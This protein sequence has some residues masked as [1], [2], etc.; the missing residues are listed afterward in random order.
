MAMTYDSTNKERL[1]KLQPHV[2]KA[3]LAALADAEK[4]GID[5]LITQ[6]LRTYAE[7]NAL[8]AKGRTAP[9]SI[10]TNARGGYSYHNF[11]L[12][13][14][15][16]LIEGGKAV[17][18][19]NSKW[20]QFA[21]IAKKHG[22]AWGGDWTRFKDYPH[23]E[24]TGGL[25]LAQCRAKWP[26]GYKPVKGGDDVSVSIDYKADDALP[27]MV[28]SKDGKDKLVSKLQKRLA[29]KVDGYFGPSTE[30]AV[31]N[32]QCVHDEKGNAVAAGKGLEVDGIVG[33][34]TWEAMFPE[35]KKE[36]PKQDKPE[37]KPP[38]PKKEE[39]PKKAAFL[40][41]VN[42]KVVAE[43]GDISEIKVVKG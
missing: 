40:V 31:K 27:L 2:A 36:E 32:W 29:I 3:A 13:F 25:T 4:V 35:P 41:V 5:I 37:P 9:G 7:Q 28:G 8:Y 12:A 39:E 30:S 20:K 38:E 21:A 42:G 22:F 11:G 23:F 18:S 17:W 6:G 19:V 24:M 1:A 33:P 10:V 16:C 34:K 43:I 26:N 15:I 14:D